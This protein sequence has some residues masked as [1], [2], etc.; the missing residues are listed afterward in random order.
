LRSEIEE[1]I[2]ETE[3]IIDITK[4]TPTPKANAPI[5]LLSLRHARNR[6]KWYAL[7]TKVCAI[8][9][10]ALLWLSARKRVKEGRQIGEQD[11]Y[12]HLTAEA[13]KMFPR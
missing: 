8:G 6:N 3:K 1:Q 7:M 12:D 11:V 4:A 5:N 2:R 13:R 10:M 9:L